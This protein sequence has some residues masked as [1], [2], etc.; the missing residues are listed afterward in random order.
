MKSIQSKTRR[1]ELKTGVHEVVIHDM[2]YLRNASKEIQKIDGFVAIVV[3]F[4]GPK[5]SI[6]DNLYIID[7]GYRQKYFQKLLVDAGVVVV[8]GQSPKKEEIVGKKLFIAIQEVHHVNDDKAVLEDGE[9]VIEYHIFKTMPIAKDKPKLTGDPE[10]NH[11]F[12]MDQFVT[13][14]NMSSPFIGSVEEVKEEA[15][16]IDDGPHFETDND[17]LPNFDV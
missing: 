3:R 8:E 12:P 2:F 14:K 17:E 4:V 16:F 11:G 10:N 9:P 5:K 7:G 13:Y 15:E 1:S 6:H